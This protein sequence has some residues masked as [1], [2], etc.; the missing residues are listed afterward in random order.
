MLPNKTGTDGSLVIPLTRRW[1][2][3]GAALPENDR[4][5][6]NYRPVYTGEVAPVYLKPTLQTNPVG[7][8]LTQRPTTLNVTDFM[9]GAGNE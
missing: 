3:S 4:V 1:H 5:G 2:E 7:T 6:T 8:G 9:R